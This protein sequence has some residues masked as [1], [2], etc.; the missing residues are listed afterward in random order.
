ML[1]SA[2]VKAARPRACAYKKADGQ[3]LYLH[4]APTGTKS[5]RFRYRDHDGREQT[6][7][8]GAVP[9]VEARTLRDAARAAIARGED[10]RSAS[11]AVTSFESAA[12]AWHAHRASAWSPVHATDVIE[13]LE[14][15]VMPAIGASALESITRPMVLDVLERVEARGAIET[16]RRLRQRIEA[17]FE[18]ARAKGWTSIANPADVRE[19][20]AAAPA[21][22][23]QAALVD[24]VELRALVAGVDALD[25][26]P[27]LRQASRFLAL[28]A[29]RLAALRGMEWCEVEDLDG[30]APIWRVP[31]ARMKLGTAKK[32]DAAN[33]HIVPLSAAAAA[34]LRAARA[35]TAVPGEPSGFVFPGRAGAQPIGAGAIGELYVRAGFG[36]RHVPHGWRASFSTVMNERRP[37]CRADIDRTLGHVPSD[38]KK[39]EIAYNRAKH[40]VARRALLDEWAEILIG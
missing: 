28:T 16:A 2:E 33:D 22:G 19:A 34:I 30:D 32:R 24:V 31:A 38:M 11:A 29:V 3:G 23:R 15:D 18:F 20:L 4:V 39:V 37:E 13:S 17:V 40:I 1:T 26:A 7:T 12:R 9:L 27:I 5:F 14:R 8:F 10:P 36:G 6:L 25:A 21:S 35:R